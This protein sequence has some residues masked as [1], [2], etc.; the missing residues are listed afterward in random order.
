MATIEL[1]GLTKRFGDVVAVDDLTFS[2]EAGTVTGFLGP[3]GAGK[4]TTMRMLLGLV[5]PTSGRATIDGRPYA[6]VAE[7]WRMVGALIDPAVFHPGRRAR[8]ELLVRTTAAGLPPASADQALE[9]VGLADVGR[10][11]V[12]GF[13]MG[14]RQRL[15]LGAALLGDPQVLILD[16]PANGLDPEGVH[17]LRQFIRDFGADGR[18]VMVSSHLLSE[19][20]QTVDDVVVIAKG[21]LV[22]QAPLHTLTGSAH[23]GGVRVRTPDIDALRTA[24]QDEALV[25]RSDGDD[26]LLVLDA[27][28]EQV[29][30]VVSR[31]GL[32]VYEMSLVQPNLEDVFLELTNP[33]RSQS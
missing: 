32:V 5:R 14:M 27:T 8:E 10:R 7:P 11:R 12:G 33:E 22:R 21:R 13:S 15:A 23:G 29:G 16:E 28:P 19:V 6:D 3:N 1:T 30:R 4:S 31:S 2:L 25:T 26:Q 17:W 18:T 20:A 24:L 9:R